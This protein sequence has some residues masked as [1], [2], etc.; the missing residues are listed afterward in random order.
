MQEKLLDLVFRLARD[1]RK[2]ILIAFGALTL[3]SAFFATRLTISTSQ[4]ALTPPRHPVQIDYQ[5]FS[6]EFGAADSLIVV[7]EGDSETIRGAADYFAAEYRGERKWVKNVFYKVDL[8]FFKKRALLF[9]PAE[10]LERSADIL[11]KQALL[12][13]KVTQI[14][15][16]T[17][18]LKSIE[19]GFSKP[20]LS[21]HP[22]AVAGILTGIEEL[23]S[24]WSRWLED[25]SRHRIDML[26]RLTAAGRGADA[27]VK[28][29]GYLV[30]RDGR[31]C[32]IFVQPTSADDESTFLRPFIGAMRAASDRVF[33][34]FP[35]LRGGVKVGFTGLPAHVLTESETVFA[36]VGSGAIYATF[37]VILVIF[38]GF[39]T[40]RKITIAVVPLIAGMV[41]SL[42]AVALILGRLNLVSAA[43]LVVMF[44]MSIDFGIY[45]LRRAEEELGAGATLEAALRTAMVQTGSGVFTGGLTMAAA[46]FA[47]TLSDFVG[48]AELG[49]TAGTGTLICLISVFFLVPTLSMVFGLEPRPANLGPVKALASSRQAHQILVVGVLV[50]VAIGAL[51]VWALRRNTFDYNA[52]HLLPRD[53]E[54]TTYQIRMHEQSD[55]QVSAAN[56]VTSSFEEMRTVVARL[57]ALPDVARVESLVDLIPEQQTQ[58]LQTIGRMRPY[59]KELRISR[60]DDPAT[61]ASYVT[62]LD[63][64]AG[65][66]ANA[67]DAAFNA[68]RSD[69]VEAM[70]KVLQRIEVLKKALTAQDPAMALARSKAFERE[71]FANAR[72]MVDLVHTWLE[73]APITESQV[74]PEVLGRF[75]SEAGHYVAYVF[76][77]ASIWE[78][79]SLDRFVA[80]LKQISPHV[81]GF[82]VTHQLNS[83]L[84]VRG[85]W[86]AMLYA[87]FAIGLLLTI[88]FRRVQPVLLALLPLAVGLLYLQ[89]VLY[90]FAIQY[91]YAN[92]AAFPVLLGYGVSYG[93]NIVQRWLEDPRGTAFV[94]AYTI[95]KGVVLSAAAAVAAL[96]AIVPARHAGVAT[97]GAVLLAGILLCFV[98]AVFLLPAVIDLMY[99]NDNED[100]K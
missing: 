92:V 76:P 90:V 55:F 87:F 20:E 39:R 31:M 68:G 77:K 65:H 26:Q 19:D 21:F 84:A 24:E 8:D 37:L 4:K 15:N 82:P 81:T 27:I 59:L 32:F 11:A 99:L 48:F 60:V 70:E 54:S 64:L 69:L 25:P 100:R 72:D 14:S 67:Q 51:S 93:V 45:V 3:V 17:L 5:R 10:A 66:F 41:I 56:V 89:L 96:L 42:G 75:K 33:T 98:T 22:D 12:I 35:N 62:L 28:S 52:L 71:L 23:F 83:K 94:S 58:K 46:F 2:Q 13:D 50:A 18:I 43:F 9:A 53:S 44:G 38:I 80:Q 29:Q 79:D 6:E 40:I 85:V 86:Q 36:D 95:G 61:T 73:S 63:S 78:M 91:N 88:N 74:A 97:F 16:V 34:R 49:I 47:V 57:K 1:H 30:S 7:L